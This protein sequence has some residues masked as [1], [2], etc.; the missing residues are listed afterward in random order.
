MLVVKMGYCLLTIPV[1]NLSEH[2]TRCHTV[3]D[4]LKL[5]YINPRLYR[6]KRHWDEKPTENCYSTLS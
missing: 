5:L 3:S 4:G 1:I 6:N 2:L